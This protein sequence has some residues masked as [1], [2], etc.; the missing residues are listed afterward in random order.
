MYWNS[1]SL[2]DM[3]TKLCSS[4]VLRTRTVQVAFVLHNFTTLI[5]QIIKLI[6]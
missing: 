3:Q 1:K 2:Q 4:F 5:Q 6:I